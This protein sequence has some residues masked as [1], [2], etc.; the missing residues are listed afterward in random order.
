M[1][2]ELYQGHAY[3]FPKEEAWW[4]LL[5][6][7]LF[8]HICFYKCW[9]M[10]IHHHKYVLHCPAFCCTYNVS[11]SSFCKL[12]NSQLLLNN[13][14]CIDFCF[15]TLN[16]YRFQIHLIVVERYKIY[17]KAWIWIFFSLQSALLCY[18]LGKHFVS[19]LTDTKIT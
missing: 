10:C 17:D 12:F 9:L 3:G 19:W 16:I 2:K 6:K 7:R 4:F 1:E 8:M 13:T 15:T 11:S 18:T 14:I 5:V